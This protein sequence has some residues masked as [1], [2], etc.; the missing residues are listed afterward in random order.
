MN[1]YYG[2][3][4]KEAISN[5][6]VKIKTVKQL[7]QYEE[8]YNFVIPEDELEEDEAEDEVEEDEEEDE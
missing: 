6:P 3:S 5:P 2:N 1:Y 7:R 8:N 4:Y